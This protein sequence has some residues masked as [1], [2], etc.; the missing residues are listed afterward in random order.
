MAKI[1]ERQEYGQSEQ[2]TIKLTTKGGKMTLLVHKVSG[3]NV[4]TKKSSDAS[5]TGEISKRLKLF[6][7][8][9]SIF[10]PKSKCCSHHF[11]CRNHSWLSL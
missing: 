4:T 9:I 5:S 7:E 10:W 8:A 6:G 2:K 1:P 3:N 11:I